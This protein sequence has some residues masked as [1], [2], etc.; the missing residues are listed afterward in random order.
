MMTIPSK[1]ICVIGDV[2]GHLQLALCMVA[3][4]QRQL[5]E[6][7]E[8]VFLCG[9]VGTFTDEN[10][11]D[12]TTRRHGKENPCELEFL[13][14]WSVSP[15]PYWL[16]AIFRPIE[17]N[18][19][20]L[21]CPVV[22]VHGNHEGFSYLE[23]LVPSVPRST[24]FEIDRLPTVDTGGHIRYLPSGFRCRTESQKI[25]AGVGGIELGQRT[26]KYHS[27]AYLD[28]A[29]ILELLDIPRFDLLVTHQGPAALQS[30]GGSE[31][32]QELLDAEKAR[33]WCHGHSIRQPGIVDAGPNDQ[34]RVVPLEDATFTK[35][36]GE[37][38]HDECFAFIRFHDTE[39]LP[40]V[41]LHGPPDDW[42]TL[43]RKNWT[44]LDEHRI[45]APMLP[46]KGS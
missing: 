10:Q 3:S 25:V 17:D 11:L 42:R 40:Q 12:S 39:S 31:N 36:G 2:H 30:D 21:T 19:L 46:A 5:G 7:F 6:S 32:L 13:Y 45:V 8:A 9:D 23:T 16:N 29:A 24:I 33:C 18:G 1:P 4:W 34:T 20:G 35:S 26:A 37:P 38:N 28:D 44:V 41:E 15:F 14:Q 22:M 27:L 43:R